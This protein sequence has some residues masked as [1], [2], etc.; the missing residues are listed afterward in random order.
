MNRNTKIA[1]GCGG[2]GCFGII[3]LGVIGLAVY[4]YMSKSTYRNYNYNVNTNVN[5]GTNRNS[6]S[7][8]S[9]SS[10]SPSS[11]SSS[12]SMAD[13][14]KHKLF[15]AALITGDADLIRRVNVKL[16]IVN[17]DFTLGT[18]YQEFLSAHADWA[19]NNTSF[20]LEVS[21]PEKGRAYVNEH[22]ED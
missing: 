20:I 14:D 16:G 15:Q 22:F 7:S 18:N 8:P 11:N 4:F 2:G 6:N 17:E 13:D 9:P 19:R 5:R 1:L 10:S 3:I 12:S 21:S